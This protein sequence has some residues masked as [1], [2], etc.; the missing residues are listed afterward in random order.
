MNKKINCPNCGAPLNGLKLCPECGTD[1]EG[2]SKIQKVLDWAYDKAVYGLSYKKKSPAKLAFK[3]AII[4][5]GSSNAQDEEKLKL[6]VID[7]VKKYQDKFPNE[8]E[9]QINSLIRR[10]VAICSAS[11]FLSGLFGVMTI[12]V[13]LPANMA[14][15]FYFQLR[16]AAA[17]ACIRGYDLESDE[18]RKFTQMCVAIQDARK[19]IEDIGAN[20]LDGKLSPQAIHDIIIKVSGIVAGKLLAKVGGKGAV[21]ISKMI[22]LIGGVAGGAIDAVWTR[23][24]ASMA[25]KNFVKIDPKIDREASEKPLSRLIEQLSA[26]GDRR[27]GAL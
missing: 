26:R 21:D 2:I 6:S 15:V 13:T 24:I 8:P 23:S 3:S 5:D 18:V 11:G 22:P 17:I 1:M 20:V 7:M 27:S 10:Q 14:S 9:K 25:K 4:T 19:M 12:P 16:M